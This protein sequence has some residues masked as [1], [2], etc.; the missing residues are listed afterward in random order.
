MFGIAAERQFLLSSME[1]WKSE[2]KSCGQEFDINRGI[3]LG[4]SFSPLPFVL[5]M[6]P[7]SFVLRR[8]NAGY[9]WGGRESTINHLLLMVNDLKLYGKSYKQIDSLLQT[10]N[11]Y[12]YS[13]DIGFQFGI[14]KCGMLVLKSGKIAKKEGIKLPEGLVI[15]EIDN[16]EYMYLGIL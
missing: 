1:E 12:M 4:D 15:K 10:D 13:T 16:S 8:S 2:L 14:K 5:C 9:V 7:L 6:V 3:F 11:P